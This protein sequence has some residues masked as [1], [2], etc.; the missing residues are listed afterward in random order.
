MVPHNLVTLS[1]INLWNP[2]FVSSLPKAV[3]CPWP[4]EQPFTFILFHYFPLPLLLSLLF[5]IYFATNW[6]IC[7][8]SLEHNIKPQVQITLKET[9]CFYLFLSFQFPRKKEKPYIQNLGVSA[10][11]KEITAIVVWGTGLWAGPNG[12]WMKYAYECVYIAKIVYRGVWR[13][14]CSLK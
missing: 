6:I 3:E 12:L 1:T 4:T 13:K 10:C 5:D 14:L 9:L 2:L 7:T 8:L 11:G